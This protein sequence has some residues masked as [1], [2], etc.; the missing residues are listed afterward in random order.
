MQAF[1]SDRGFPMLVIAIRPWE[2]YIVSIDD[3]MCSHA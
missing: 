2:D 1:V 3:C